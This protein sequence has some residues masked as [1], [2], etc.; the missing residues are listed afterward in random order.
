MRM[1][2]WQIQL[3]KKKVCGLNPALN[4]GRVMQW[5]RAIIYN[6]GCDNEGC[7]AALMCEMLVG[8]LEISSS[9]TFFFNPL[10]QMSM[11]YWQT[12]PWA[13]KEKHPP[14]PVC[15]S[16]SSWGKSKR[17]PNWLLITNALFHQDFMCWPSL[18]SFGNESSWRAAADSSGETPGWQMLLQR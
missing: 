9:F 6:P 12:E 1:L 16:A 15:S 17:L 11:L 10:L 14:L 8:R 2:L 18:S 3:K 13:A 7:Q 5:S 4:G